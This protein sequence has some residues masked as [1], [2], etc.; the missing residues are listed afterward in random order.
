[1]FM[2][3]SLFLT[4]RKKSVSALSRDQDNSVGMGSMT[5]AVRLLLLLKLFV[6]L[7]LCIHD[8]AGAQPPSP[9][10]AVASSDLRLVGTVQSNTFSG[11]VLSDA[12][13]TQLFYR[14]HERLPDE[15]QIVKVQS[16]S[17]LLKR[18]DGMLYELFV[19]QE[20]KAAVPASAP[21]NIAPAS[22]EEEIRK[23]S[24]DEKRP[25]RKQRTRKSASEE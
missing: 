18:T 6:S 2:D 25:I 3:V 19:T 17:I 22:H 14:L 7:D 12:S 9:G 4:G 16:D 15:S 24:P 21:A 8:Q 20:T 10:P 5:Q 11:A 23:T 13:G 1:M